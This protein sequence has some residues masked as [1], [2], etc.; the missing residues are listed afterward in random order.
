MVRGEG[1]LEL[2]RSG[3]G[4]TG[5]LPENRVRIRPARDM[6][7]LVRS[8]AR[9]ADF[10]EAL[11]RHQIASVLEGGQEFYERA[12]T[13]AVVAA[14][15]AISNPH[16]AVSLYAALKSLLFSFSDED[17]LREQLAGVKFRYDRP[18][19]ASERLGRAFDLFSRLRQE[20]HA[21]SA[22]DTMDELDRRPARSRS[23]GREARGCRPRRT[24]SGSP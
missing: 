19:P 5:H 18:G 9:V 13:A 6:A 10:Q 22:R 4:R 1:H 12:E 8:N 14:L 23:R 24:S 11:D 2:L 7:I 3:L 15:K 21:R 20:R 17:L 16:D